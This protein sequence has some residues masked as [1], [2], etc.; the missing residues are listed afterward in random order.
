MNKTRYELYTKGNYDLFLKNLTY[1][2][3]H[4]DGDKIKIRVPRI[5]GLHKRFE[6]VET[7]LKLRSMGFKNIE[8]VDYID[9]VEKYKKISK[10]AIKN[11]EDFLEKI[12]ER[13]E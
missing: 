10:I 9:E 5:K 11:R 2:K 13:E 1:L 4:V 6:F 7:D 12:N 3:D 8:S